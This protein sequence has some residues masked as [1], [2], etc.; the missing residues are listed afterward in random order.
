M[1]NAHVR[2]FTREIYYFSRLQPLFDSRKKPTKSLGVKARFALA[3]VTAAQYFRFKRAQEVL[4]LTVG[5]IGKLYILKGG[6]FR[7]LESFVVLD[8]SCD[9]DVMFVTGCV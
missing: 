6:N 7:E 3:S 9:F 5:D 8:I 1:L 4:S 2:L